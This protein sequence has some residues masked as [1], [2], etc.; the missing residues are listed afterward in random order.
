[1]ERAD[2]DVLGESYRERRN[3]GVDSGFVLH[4]LQKVSL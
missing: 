4:L 2:N 3:S 1:M